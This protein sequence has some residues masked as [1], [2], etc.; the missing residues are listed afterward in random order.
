MKL[1]PAIFACITLFCTT[2]SARAELLPPNRLPL[3]EEPDQKQKASMLELLKLNPTQSNEGKYPQGLIKLGASYNEG[4]TL[5]DALLMTLKYN[6]PIK[7]AQENWNYQRYQLLAYL[8]GIVPSY[9]LSYAVNKTHVRPITDAHSEVF[10][11]EVK[12]PVFLGGSIFYNSLSQYYRNLAWK[13]N[14]QAT[15]SDKLLET[16]QQY[17]DL[18]LQE[19]LLQIQYKSVEIAERFLQFDQKMYNA[20]TSTQYNVMKSRTQFFAAR[21]SFDKQEASKR[22]AAITLAYT[23]NMPMS[24]NLLPREEILKV[25]SLT[26]QMKIDECVDLALKNRPELRQYELFRLAA[27]RSVQA[28]AATLYPQLSFFTALTKAD[29]TVTPPDNGDLLNGVASGEVAAAQ[30]SEGNVITNTALN[31]TASVSPGENNTG[32]EGATIDNTVVAGGG[33]TPIANAQGGSLVTSGAVAPNF[34]ADGVTGKSSASN[35]NGAD[36]AGAGVFPGTSTNFQKGFNLEWSLSNMGLANLG[37]ILSARSLS[38]QA[39]LQANQE[40]LLVTKQ[41]HAAYTRLHYLGQELDNAIYTTWAA[42]ETLRFA[43]RRLEAGTA[44]SLDVIYARRDYVTALTMQANAVAAYNLAQAQLL[45]DMGVI[46]VA[47][48][49]DGMVAFKAEKRRRFLDW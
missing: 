3:P 26:K 48:L 38:K 41:V 18:C 30:E 37:A 49:T 32:T 11:S 44:S 36:T 8:A 27:A 39:M 2:Q 28:S 15:I 5:R 47:T 25:L 13:R 7:I 10:T 40:L 21:E 31:Q 12:Y 46:S 42:N 16:F 29:V 43:A 4:I 34:G 20:G 14:H 9:S 45:H 1:V 17:N 6:L 19:A 22:Q 24:A 35:I 33:G 23:L